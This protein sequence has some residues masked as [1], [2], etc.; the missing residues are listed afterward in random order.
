MPA[1]RK[2]SQR[3]TDEIRVV[4]GEAV[5]AEL[6]DPQ[7][8]EVMLNADG[9]VWVEKMGGLIRPA[10]KLSAGNGE[11]ICRI[12]ASALHKDIEEDHPILEGEL[13]LDGSRFEGILPPLAA[14]PIFTIRKRAGAVFTLADYV[15]SGVMTAH[16]REVIEDAIASRANILIVGGTGSGKTTLVNGCIAEVVRQFPDERIVII[17]DTGEIQCEAKNSVQLHSTIRTSMTDL[18]KATLRLRPDRILVGEVRGPE[19][20]DLLMAWGTGHP[21]GLATL[22]ANG[23]LAALDRLRLLVS[24]NPSAPKDS[25][26]LIGEAVHYVVFIARDRTSA[27]ARRVREIIR[28]RGYDAAKKEYQAEAL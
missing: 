2:N 20:L 3:V 12:V 18:L 19:A 25:E 10:A 4:L 26:I 22:H 21:G 11:R 6:Q 5:M 23:A 17:E 7:T 9:T 24:M 13:P 27:G 8:I 28:V 16:H 15:A 14:A 1:L